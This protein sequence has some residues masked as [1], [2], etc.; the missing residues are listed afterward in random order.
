MS[1]E[2]CTCCGAIIP[3]SRQ[4]CRACEIKAE[5]TTSMSVS[6][7]ECKEHGLPDGGSRTEFETGAVRDIQTSKGRR[8]LL[9]LDVIGRIME[10]KEVINSQKSFVFKAIE[11][12]KTY[13]EYDSL[14]VAISEFCKIRY[15]NDYTQ[16]YLDLAQHF[17]AGAKKYGDNNWQKG[18][19]TR[20]YIASAVGHYLKWLRG[21]T[22]EAHDRAF[23]WNLI[24]CIW[25][26]IHMPELN[27]YGKKDEP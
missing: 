25:T 14:Y 13:G 7:E 16:M 18:I 22:D 19:P 17:E 9:P 8:D 24:C 1:E 27:D 15:D 10:A 2:T 5:V 26:C 4:V 20:Y 21:D 6:S 12:F 11:C 3:E 23:V